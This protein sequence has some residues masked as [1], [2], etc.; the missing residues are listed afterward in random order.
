MKDNI[1]KI[2]KSVVPYLLSLLAG[3]YLIVIFTGSF[4]GLA[5]YK[6]AFSEKFSDVLKE[7]A[8]HPLSHYLAYIHEKTPL[9]I[10]LSIALILYLIYFA[11][12][13]KKAKG[14]WETAD[15]ETHG[16]ADWGNSKELFSKYFGVGQKKLKEDFDNSIDQEIIDKL[17][18]E[19]VEE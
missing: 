16:S 7:L 10:I 8:L 4:M 6:I 15:T 13:R 14:S 3:L 1:I 11:L 12:R 2:I 17:N 5:Q 19:R 9:A 18:K